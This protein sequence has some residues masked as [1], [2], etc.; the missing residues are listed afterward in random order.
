MVFGASC[1]RRRRCYFHTALSGIDATAE[2]KNT[3]TPQLT[4]L[5]SA[6][7]L[8]EDLSLTQDTVVRF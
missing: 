6:N 8:Q 5:T 7:V 2:K 4:T 1:R 3:H